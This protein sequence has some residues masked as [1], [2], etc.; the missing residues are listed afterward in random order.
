MD[1]FL[2][3][4]SS[5][6]T[7]QVSQQTNKISENT[8]IGVNDD[9]GGNKNVVDIIIITM[10]NRSNVT[11]LLGDSGSGG[12]HGVAARTRQVSLRASGSLEHAWDTCH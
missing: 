7:P 11:L 1:V 8:R 10:Q 3:S 12:G 9:V 6:T 4:T 5:P 2:E